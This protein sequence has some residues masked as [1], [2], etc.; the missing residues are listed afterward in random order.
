M[1]QTCT[2][3][4]TTDKYFT[5]KYIQTLTRSF[6]IHTETKFIEKNMHLY[7]NI[8]CIIIIN[9]RITKKLYG[10]GEAH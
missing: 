3:D 6:S 10:W 2:G 1:V 7:S 4:K 5:N 8:L 9:T